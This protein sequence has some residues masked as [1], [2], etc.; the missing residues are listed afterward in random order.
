[1]GLVNCIG[2]FSGVLGSSV[3][4]AAIPRQN[5]VNLTLYRVTPLGYSGL[6]NMDSGNAAGDVYFGISQLL[7]PQMCITD[8]GGLG[9]TP[10]APIV[11]AVIALL[12]PPP[13]VGMHACGCSCR[14]A[15]H[16]NN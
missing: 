1:M 15:A 16:T 10:H 4:E 12:R 11:H 6:T 13:E 14:R 8:V 5:W 2:I 9:Y 7:L 3:L